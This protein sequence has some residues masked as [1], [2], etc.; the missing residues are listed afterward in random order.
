MTNKM[1]VADVL[2]DGF[3]RVRELVASV[4]DGLSVEQL[5]YRQQ[6]D[7]NSIGWLIWHLTRVQDDHVADAAD[8]PQVWTAQDWHSRFELPFDEAATGY[9]HQSADVSA[10]SVEAELLAGYHEAVVAQSLDYVAGLTEDDLGRVVDDAWDPP[11]TLGVRLISVLS[12]DLQHVGQAAY[13][14]G[15]LPH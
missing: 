13:L 14:R 6:P 7:A 11:V 1:T 9:G 15:Q 10:V 8:R 12:D 3:G 2:A 4:L 5:S